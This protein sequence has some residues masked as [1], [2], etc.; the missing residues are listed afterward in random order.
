VTLPRPD[1]A[2]VVVRLAFVPQALTAVVVEGR[3][4]DR[5]PPQIAEFYRRQ[6]R[7][8]GRFI[9][10]A[11]IERRNPLRT[12]DLLRGVPG[13]AVYGD[14][15]ATAVRYRSSRCAPEV[16]LDGLALTAGPVDLDA[17][18]PSSLEGIEVHSLGTVPV[19]YSRA[20]GRSSCGTVMLW[21]RYG[22]PRPRRSRQ[23]PVTSEELAQLVG[24][25]RI[26]TAA[27][28]DSA[29]RAPEDFGARFVL[30]DS[31]Q[32]AGTLSVIA[33]FVVDAEGRVEPATV[34]LV[35]SPHPT[36]SEAV[37]AAL[38]GARFTPAVLAGRPVRQLVQV[39]VRFDEKPRAGK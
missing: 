13:M 9:T 25:L 36:L 12:T 23:K 24:A 37:R 10:R 3:A 21:S 32:V 35:A 20:F 19:E 29:A 1:S 5:R 27:Q 14:G 28:V 8:M 11:E 33:E 7:G 39:A 15:G 34:N 30:A 16:Y 6:S 38:P 4:T 22:E 31:A 18:A 26:Y 17:F 2:A